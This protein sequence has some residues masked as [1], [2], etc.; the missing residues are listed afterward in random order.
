MEITFKKADT[1]DV[2]IVN[3][4]LRKLAEY[5]KLADLC[6]IT[7]E[8]LAELMTEENGLSAV[9]AM[10]DGKPVGVLTYY[11]FKIATFS[12]MRVLYVED[13]FVDEHY[14]NNGIGT[15][16][17]NIIKDTAVENMCARIEWK[18]LKWNTSAQKFYEKINGKSSDEWLTYTLEL[19]GG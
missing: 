10:A 3:K 19:N 4:M 17:F 15:K 8:R 18:C 12:G 13:I 11:F 1:S 6:K 2:S 16:F 9:I 14:R 7:D 5:E